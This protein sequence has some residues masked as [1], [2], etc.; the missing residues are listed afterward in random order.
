ML[1][2][3]NEFPNSISGFTQSKFLG[4]SIEDAAQMSLGF[5]SGK[6]AQITFAM[7]SEPHPLVCD[8]ELIGTRGSLLVH[9]WSGYEHRSATGSV[10]R[11]FYT[12]ESHVDKVL[13]GLR[14]EIEELCAAI[15]ENRD[16]QPT[17]EES[18]RALEVI[19]TFYDA[20]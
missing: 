6:S 13:V 10:Q 4:Q 11:E 5:P 14:G 17:V 2:F 16:P 1:W 7:L 18:T 20:V 9:T 19:S 15:R 12:S 8:L 3:A